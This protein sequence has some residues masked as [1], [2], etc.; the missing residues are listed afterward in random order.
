MSD[1]LYGKT[2]EH[3]NDAELSA[4]TFAVAIINAWNRLGVS[5]TPVPGSM[6]KAWGLDRAGLS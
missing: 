2:R 1:G 6:D 4:L 3:F 5:F